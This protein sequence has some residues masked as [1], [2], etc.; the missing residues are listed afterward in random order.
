[1]CYEQKESEWDSFVAE[2]CG[3]MYNLE[4]RLLEFSA[5]AVR[6]TESMTKSRAGN[7]VAG[8]LLRSST[9]PLANHG[10]AQAAESAKD[11][12]H[13]LKLS[14]KELRETERWIK[15]TEHVPL[16]ETPKRLADLLDETD[17]LIRIFVSSVNTAS[18]NKQA[19]C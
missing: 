9:S 2:D 4:A 17:Q 8:Q 11:F 1:M 10:E 18:N 14:L 15:L 5:R 7:H 16:V 3:S 6:L 12:I 19:T 13:K